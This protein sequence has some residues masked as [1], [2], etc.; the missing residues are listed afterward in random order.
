ML[1]QRLRRWS[2]IK[3]THGANPGVVGGD[4]DTVPRAYRHIEM[5]RQRVLTVTACAANTRR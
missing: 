1:N 2:N 3:R 4:S 5:D